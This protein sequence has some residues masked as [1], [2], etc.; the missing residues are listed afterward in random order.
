M[1]TIYIL[2]LGGG[3]RKWQKPSLSLWDSTL[4]LIKILEPS[5]INILVLRLLFCKVRFSPGICIDIMVIDCAVEPACW[6]KGKRAAPCKISICMISVICIYGQGWN[7]GLNRQRFQGRAND[8]TSAMA[9]NILIRNERSAS[10][11]DGV[12]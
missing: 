8:V 10:V 9:S 6:R 7:A 2:E 5:S 1:S 3:L 12:E 11:F 4:L